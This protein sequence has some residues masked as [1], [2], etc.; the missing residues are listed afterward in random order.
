MWAF[1]HGMCLHLLRRPVGL[2][3]NRLAYLERGKYLRIEGQRLQVYK[4]RF[5]FGILVLQKTEVIRNLLIRIDLLV[6]TFVR[7]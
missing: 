1:A 7:D 3:M 6:N 2:P 4:T 5:R